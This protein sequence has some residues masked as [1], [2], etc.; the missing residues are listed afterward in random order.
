MSILN[1]IIFLVSRSK[2]DSMD[3]P[4][5]FHLTLT[6][7]TNYNALKHQIKQFLLANGR[8]GPNGER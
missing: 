5:E 7:S 6:L 2:S 3:Y 1:L 8:I 4:S